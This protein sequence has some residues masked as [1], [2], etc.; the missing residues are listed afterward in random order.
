MDFTKALA[1]LE[2]KRQ[3]QIGALQNTDY[4][5]KAIKEAQACN[6]ADPTSAKAHEAST[7][8]NARPIRTTNAS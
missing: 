2:T 3:R 4:M 1:D 7:A 6:A 8:T 5:I